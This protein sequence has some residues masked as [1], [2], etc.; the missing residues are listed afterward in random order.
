M[1]RRMSLEFGNLLSGAAAAVTLVSCA[2]CAFSIRAGLR[3]RRAKPTGSLSHPPVSFLKPLKGTDPGMYD[4]L[5]SHCRLDY[6]EYEMLLGVTDP[7][8]P[9]VPL[10]QKLIEEFP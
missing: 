7:D 3:F 6:P 8:D 1:A 4:A 9:A 5:R 10:V 2:Y